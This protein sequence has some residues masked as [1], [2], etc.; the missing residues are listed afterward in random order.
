[1]SGPIGHHILARIFWENKIE[2]I[3]SDISTLVVGIWGVEY[4][5]GGVSNI[6]NSGA[7]ILGEAQPLIWC[8]ANTKCGALGIHPWWKWKAGTT[9]MTYGMKYISNI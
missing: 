6:E 2:C 3:Y 8:K 5:W 7:G 4:V 9:K 1:M